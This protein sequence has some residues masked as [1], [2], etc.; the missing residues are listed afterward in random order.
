MIDLP[1]T[2]VEGVIM[3]LIALLAYIYQQD[4]R[5]TKVRMDEFSSS[6][7]RHSETISNSTVTVALQQQQITY[8]QKQFDEMFSMLREILTKLDGKQDK[9]H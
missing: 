8:M 4:Q 1:I 2:W 3:S 7:Q 9:A 5:A 6:L